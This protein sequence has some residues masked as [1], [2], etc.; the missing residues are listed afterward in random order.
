MNLKFKVSQYT[1]ATG[2]EGIYRSTNFPNGVVSIV[3]S[4]RS[5]YM[6]F[7][8]TGFPF[9]YANNGSP[10]F[11]TFEEAKKYIEEFYSSP[12]PIL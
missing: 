2:S 1:D 8:H 6:T 5:G 4:Q 7:D 3:E 10:F 9:S 12:R 11:D